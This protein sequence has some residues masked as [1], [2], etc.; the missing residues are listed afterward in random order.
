M[1]RFTGVQCN[2]TSAYHPQSNGLDERFNQTLQRQ[3]KKFVDSEQKN[4]DQYLDAILFSYSPFLVYGRH[5]HLPIE[6][7]MRP[8]SYPESHDMDSNLERNIEVF[9]KNSIN[10][11]TCTYWHAGN[12]KCVTTSCTKYSE[13]SVQAEGILLCCTQH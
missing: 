10:A 3:L 7:N 11:I 4:W 8:N 1:C 12:D 6:F 5:P 9:K 2:L 13:S